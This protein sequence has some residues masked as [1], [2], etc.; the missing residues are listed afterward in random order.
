MSRTP[1]DS[2]PAPTNDVVPLLWVAALAYVILLSYGVARSAIDSLLLADHGSGALKY[3]Y[4]AV[5]ISVTIVVAIYGR[6]AARRPLGSVLGAS[7]LISAAAL[8]ALLLARLSDVPG[9]AYGLYIWKDVYVVVLV[10]LVWTLANSAFKQSTAAWAYGFFCVAGTLGDM[11]GSYIAQAFAHQIG[12]AQLLWLALPVLIATGIVGRCAA[13][14]CGWPA[15]APRSRLK[16]VLAVVRES[17]SIQLLLAVVAV[18]QVATTLIDYNYRAT[19]LEVYP[20]LDDRT[21]IFGQVDMIISAASMLLQF[22]AGAFVSILGVRLLIVLLPLLVGA[23]AIYFAF[24]PVF[25]AL[26]VLKVLNKSLDYSLFRTTK[27]LLYRPLNYEE[28][29]QGKA[30]VD[31]FG[32]RVAKGGATGLLVLLSG[33]VALVAIASALGIVIWFGLALLLASRFQPE[34]TAQVAEAP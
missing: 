33:S 25:A 20:L 23:V 26:A 9:T 14:A 28:K 31:V 32:Y 3:A 10:E 15:P 24:H 13:R 12:T 2:D 34:E 27:E 19:A 29:T 21:A 7:A 18:I 6:A 22:L 5:A 1:L 8:V 30:A 4:G 16:G 11:S 17:R